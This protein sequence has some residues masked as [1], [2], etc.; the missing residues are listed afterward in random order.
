MWVGELV[1]D[2]NEEILL[3]TDE[4]KEEEAM[5]RLSRVGYDNT[6]GY[7]KGG[8]DTWK[9]A[10]KEV[11]FVN[12]IYAKDFKKNNYN[13][14]IALFDVRKKSEYNSE[15]VIGAV[16][17]PLNEI[18][19]HLEQF[20]KD[21]PFIIHCAGGYRSMIAASILKQR[22]FGNFADVEGG[23]AAIT[24]AGVPKTDYVCPTTLL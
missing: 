10:G 17:I 2:I 1:K 20:P 22:G 3:V 14:H 18:N 12:R 7:L 5:I 23:F 8:F 19:E 4:G 6:I 11:D 21:R 15:H 24:A 16:N 9:K 13:K